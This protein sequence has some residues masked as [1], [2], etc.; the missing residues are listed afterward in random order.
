MATARHHYERA[1]EA[2]LRARRTPYV[3]VNEARRALLPPKAKLEA[4]DTATGESVSLKSFDFVV[5]GSPFN[6]LVEVKGRKVPGSSGAAAATR[7]QLQSW[8]T[9]DD[10]VALERWQG[11][12]GGDF[13]SAF[14]FVYW[15]ERQPPD[16]LFQ[17][18][19]EH[20]SRWYAVRAVLLDE[21]KR[22][23]KTRSER[24]RTVHVP[25]DAFERISGPL[26]SASPGM[27]RRISSTPRLQAEISKSVRRR[28][29]GR[30][31]HDMPT[32]SGSG[33]APSASKR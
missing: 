20:E 26:A 27:P 18:V 4:T 3:S 17:E 22:E 32:E 29:G 31:H 15:C 25:T 10:V 8:V 12:F 1:I 21:Y 7:S 33:F 19:F 2:Y 5:Y 11:L 28:F 9:R 14:V 13:R 24:W 6:L 30:P 16:A 23:M